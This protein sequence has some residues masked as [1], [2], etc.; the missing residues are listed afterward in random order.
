MRSIV[1]G[2]AGHIDHGKSALV[3]ALTGTDPDRLKEEQAR[4]IT[5]DLGF[6]HLESDGVNLAFVDVPGHERFVKNMLAG[7]GG[8]DL[9]MLVVA[10]DESV[11]PQTREHFQICRLLHIPA[12]VIVLTKAD[13]AD[14]DTI[15]LAKIEV[16]ELT[17]GSFLADAPIVVVSARTGLGLDQLRRTLVDLATSVRE[18]DGAGLVRLPIDRVFSVKGFGTVVTGTLVSGTIHDETELVVLP[19]ERVVKVRGLQVHGRRETE[20]DPGHRVAV[21]LGGV[22]V[23]QIARGDTLCARRAFEPTQRLDAV[24][25]LL[26]DARP[27]RHGSRVRFHQ[28]TTELL[29]RVAVAA[30]RRE[31]ATIA[32]I[33]PGTSAYVRIRLEAPAVL[34]RGDRFILRAYSPS[35]TIG[36]GFVLDPHPPRVGVRTTTALERFRRLDGPDGIG[37]VDSA[38]LAFVDE[39]GESGLQANALISRVGLSPSSAE[40]SMGRLIG[41][42]SVVRVADLLVA[43]SVLQG[44]A[45]RLLMALKSHHDSQPLSEGLPREEARERLFGRSSPHIFDHVLSTLAAAGQIV[46]RDR[47]ALAGHRVSLSGEDSRTRD[48]IERIL[49][50][51][52]LAPPDAATLQTLV[53]AS[54]AIVDR[55]SGLLVRQ[56][57]LVKLDA[58]L[59]HAD[60]LA[61]L[62]AD[63]RGL[64]T[65]ARVDVP[66]FKERYGITRKYAIPLLEYLDRERIT[67]RVG[68][69]R[70]VL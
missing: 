43:P 22:D 47:L 6:A 19:R 46:V 50:E 67:R 51:A 42:G 27:L 36:G 4:G 54:A 1:I 9:A 2:T 30:D 37:G 58:L 41:A 63:V 32:E 55:I 26:P 21:N 11:M 44:L 66:S 35:I 56:K 7:A 34:T 15:E 17:A 8:V 14:A 68:D 62:K 61:R 18:R 20:A 29:G 33:E 52:G 65:N 3:R 31:I 24:V 70:V 28:G 53:N 49:K 13:L 40:T 38:V 23:G 10:A 45:E 60:A 39:R 57:T 59:F 64:K 5:I 69:A 25:E 48:E 16:R 12:G